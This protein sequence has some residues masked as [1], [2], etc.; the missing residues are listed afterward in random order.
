MSVDT[1]S[2]TLGLIRVGARDS[3]LRGWP[4]SRAA[5]P[6]RSAHVPSISRSKM[7]WVSGVAYPNAHNTTGRLPVRRTWTNPA[8]TPE[9]KFTSQISNSSIEETSM[10]L[11]A[12]RPR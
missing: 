10:L 11:A 5:H 7:S 8:E 2:M 1:T 4:E 3:A 6:Q 9:K 12:T